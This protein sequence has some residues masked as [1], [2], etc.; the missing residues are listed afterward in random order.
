MGEKVLIYNK[1]TGA[2]VAIPAEVAPAWCAGPEGWTLAPTSGP[3]VESVANA[4]VS[5]EQE[6]ADREAAQAEAV[7][8]AKASIKEKK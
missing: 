1:N 5:A 2:T 3:K 7:E 4:H 8:T 6:L